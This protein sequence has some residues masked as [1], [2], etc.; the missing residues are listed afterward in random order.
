MHTVG[1]TINIVARSLKDN[2]L[3]LQQF[4]GMN[5]G[6]PVGTATCRECSLCLMNTGCHLEGCDMTLD[7][8]REVLFLSDFLLTVSI[9]LGFHFITCDL[10]NICVTF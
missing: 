3:Q 10:M 4:H 1:L 5:A 6:V 9:L 7:L 2:A 8:V